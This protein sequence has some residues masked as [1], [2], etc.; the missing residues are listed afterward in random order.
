MAK[1]NKREKLEG[2]DACMLMH[3]ALRKL[4]DSKITSAAYNLVYLVDV[5]PHKFDPWRFFGQLVA[6]HLNERVAH[7]PANAV[8]LAIEELDD[9]YWGNVTGPARERRE[10][11]PDDAQTWLHAL[12][13][14]LQ[15]FDAKDVESMAGF[16][17][18][19]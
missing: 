3:T 14:T 17:A 13:C 6:D 19:E 4:C 18:D 16:L 7:T 10:T 2:N 5:E 8:K 9:A 1:K 11:I 15:C 12:S